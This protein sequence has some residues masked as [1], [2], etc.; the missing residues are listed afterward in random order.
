[1]PKHDFVIIGSGLGGLEC[2]ALLSQRGYDVMVLE[3][4][5]QIGGNLQTF[6]RDK[7]IFDTGVHYIGGMEKGQNLYQY[8]KYFGI[9]DDLKIRKMDEDGFDVISFEGDDNEY[10]HAQGYDNFVEVLARQFPKERH[11]LEK[12]C[13]KIRE[14]CAS[15]PMYNLYPTNNDFLNTNYLDVSA[16]DFINSCTS[17]E[18]LQKVLGGNN[19]LYAGEGNKTP[20]YVHA[21]IA[22]S[23]IESSWRCLDGGSQIARHLAKKIRNNG[24]VIKSRTEVTG[25]E[26]SGSEIKAAVLKN[27]EKIEA[28]KFISN[29][30]PSATLKMITEGRVRKAYRD[31]IDALENSIST[32]LTFLVPKKDSIPYFNFNYYHFVDDDIWNNVN[33]KDQWPPNVAIFTHASSKSEEYAEAMTLMAYMKF[34]EMD[35]WAHSFNT[36]AEK[37]F[38][39]ESYEAFKAEKAE[40][41]IDIAERKIPDLRNKIHAYYTST[42]LTYRD[43]IG[44]VDGSIYG[45]TK[46]YK[47]PLRSFLSPKTKIP[48]LYLTGQNLNL[49]GIL[50][51]TI[52][53]L[54]T[55]SEFV[56]NKELMSKIRQS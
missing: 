6:S 37:D 5:K 45:I 19:M 35:E 26:F 36:V 12:Y 39:G 47:N 27:G 24:G 51:V 10:R 30:H 25:F 20:L 17:D 29:V 23:Y 42:P 40:I 15:F 56:D 16:K 8:F 21:M 52:G 44:T 28:K 50:G 14:V 34:D 38:R 49:H 4:N 11:N 1:M 18:K 32:F 7:C 46:D 3:K 55:C 13:N 22:N 2:A 33:Y 53:S 54:V 48:N 31:R 43:Y 41:M 9:M